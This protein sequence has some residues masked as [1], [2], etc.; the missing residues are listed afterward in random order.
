MYVSLIVAANPAFLIFLF[1][2][3][4]IMRGILVPSEK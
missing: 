4:I 3:N 1:C 2:R